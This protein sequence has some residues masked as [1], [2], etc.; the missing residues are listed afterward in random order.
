[1]LM[2]RFSAF[3]FIDKLMGRLVV[4]FIDTLMGTLSTVVFI[5]NTTLDT[6]NSTDT[7]N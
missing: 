7:R 3:F 5:D 6:Q 1:M 2:G 4:F